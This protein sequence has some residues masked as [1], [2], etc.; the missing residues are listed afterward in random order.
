MVGLFAP[1]AFM[2]LDHQKGGEG[3]QIYLERRERM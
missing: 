2:T 3:D 1:I